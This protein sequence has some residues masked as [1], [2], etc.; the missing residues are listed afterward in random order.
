MSVRPWTFDP[1]SEPRGPLTLAVALERGGVEAHD[2]V[3][4]PTR[5]VVISDATFVANGALATRGNANRD[6]F[7]NSVAWLAGLDTL[8]AVRTPGNVIVT[9]L[10]RNGWLRFGVWTGVLIMAFAALAMLSAFRRR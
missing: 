9:G 6:F 8:N 2:L 4:R 1:T 10:D 7:L 3:L 5:L